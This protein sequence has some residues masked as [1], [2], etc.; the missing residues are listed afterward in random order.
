METPSPASQL[1]GGCLCTLWGG[2]RAPGEDQPLGR[3]WGRSSREGVALALRALQTGQDQALHTSAVGN[4]KPIP[5]L[6]LALSGKAGQPLQ[7]LQ[8]HPGR[9]EVEGRQPGMLPTDKTSEENSLWSFALELHIMEYLL[10]ETDDQESCWL[11]SARGE[12]EG[13][14]S[15]TVKTSRQNILL[16]IASPISVSAVLMHLPITVPF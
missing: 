7:S 15:S 14:A 8:G 9:Q 11:R 6:A 3:A 2:H 12:G 5:V 16:S 4:C 13:K 10:L 1:A